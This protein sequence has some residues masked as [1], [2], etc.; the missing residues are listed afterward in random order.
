MAIRPLSRA[1]APFPR[2]QGCVA[3]VTHSHQFP[4]PALAGLQP[5]S[6]PAEACLT[7][8]VPTSHDGGDASSLRRPGRLKKDR[9]ETREIVQARPPQICSP[10]PPAAT[11]TA[12]SRAHFR[13]N[14]LLPRLRRAVMTL[15]TLWRC[16]AVTS[17]V[18]SQF[19]ALM[20]RHLW[21]HFGRPG[22]AHLLSRKVC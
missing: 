20:P 22:L 18:F 9:E 6:S 1:I 16:V 19:E 21:S 17:L 13:E 14:V 3:K 12:G 2:E 4:S 11:S 10:G 5:Q 15:T 7:Y 8:Q